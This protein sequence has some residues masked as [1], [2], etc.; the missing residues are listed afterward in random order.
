M[1]H[2]LGQFALAAL[3]TAVLAGCDVQGATGQDAPPPPEV[4]VAAVLVEA[5]TIN[6]TFTGRLEAPETVE[7]RPRV[8]GYIESVTFTEGEL[9]DAGDV[10]FEI[11]A[12]PYEARARAARAELEGARNQLQL[13][14]QEAER[15]RELMDDRAISREE[16]DQRV[17]ALA[18]AQAR[19]ALAEATVETAELDLEYTR[20]I[21]P[22]SG[23]AGR[24]LVTRGN[25]ANANQSL[26]TTIVSVN[27]L[28]VYFN[29][30]ESDAHGSR[31]LVDPRAGTPVRVTLGGATETNRMA[32]LDYI[33]NRVDPAT[34]TLTFRAELPNPD[35]LFTPG[36]FARVDMPVTRLDQ[37][38]LVDRKAVLTDQ[39]RRY[40]Y[41]I[42]DDNTAA[43]RDVVPG[44]EA[45]SL[46]VINAGLEPG[47]RVVVNGT[48]RIF[49]P[50][51]PVSPNPVAMRP[52]AGDDSA[53]VA[54]N[55]R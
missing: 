13:A 32:T 19:V 2:R 26:L 33:D 34:G 49:F 1:T 48:Q 51:M 42:G 27:P 30:N 5:V 41:V 18:D 47:D 7:L 17:A 46:L 31:Q 37:A 23:R 24:A 39:D 53:A 43:R 12:R 20:V 38:I 6:E 14:G 25:L 22:V 16:H 54:Q 4:D 11:D 29:S 28:H 50:G 52:G 15:A 40:V 9:V 3:A 35:G 55:Q 45:G 36:Q 44:S 21:A 10:L 8:S